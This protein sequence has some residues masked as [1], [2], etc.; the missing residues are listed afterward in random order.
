M[1]FSLI[2]VL[3]ISGLVVIAIGSF[4]ARYIV[5]SDL[6]KP[7]R[8]QKWLLSMPII[9]LI[10]LIIAF[11]YYRK[12]L[13]LGLT[14][15]PTPLTSPVLRYGFDEGTMGWVPQTYKGNQAVINVQQSNEH[16][17]FG[18]NSLEVQIELIGN[19]EQKSVGE[20]FVDLSNNPPV[21]A[22]TPF[23]LT[24]KLITMWVYVPSAAIGNPNAPNGIEVFVKDV[25]DK[26]QYSEWM[27][28]TSANTDK[29][30]TVTL[31][32]SANAGVDLSNLKLLGLKIGAG[33]KSTAVFR[34]SIWI[35]GVSWP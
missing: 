22:T 16:I 8:A 29:W 15:V 2:F 6:E 18:Q 12:T 31:I 30:M 28:L 10:G 5:Q 26:S 7:Q 25:N 3:V 17:K 1:D 27:N 24:G 19:D 34:G 21:G 32:P 35:G 14:P 23:D 20:V 33:E 9:V 11:N 13:E 4:Y